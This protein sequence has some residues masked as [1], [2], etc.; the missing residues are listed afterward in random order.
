MQLIP[1]ANCYSEY[2]TK[3]SKGINCCFLSLGILT[4]GYCVTILSNYILPVEKLLTNSSII[5]LIADAFWLHTVCF[6]LKAIC[7]CFE[8]KGKA[9]PQV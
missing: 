4:R 1:T 7:Y 8:T 9:F 3:G 2:W 6:H 5:K